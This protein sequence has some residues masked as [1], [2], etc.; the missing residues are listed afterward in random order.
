[1]LGSLPVTVDP[2][3]LADKNSRLV[4]RVAIRGMTRLR[5][6][7]QDDSGQVEVDLSFELAEHSNLRRMRGRLAV[8]V[9]ATCQ[10]CLEPMS[11]KLEAEPDVV[12]LREGELEG[13][14][15]L[16]ADTLMLGQTPIALAELIED[17]LLLAMPMV[18]M[19]PLEE[20][21]ARRYTTG[22][23]EGAGTKIRL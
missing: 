12:L 5:A 21:P 1:M 3:L 6:P 23:G 22:G 15:P 14:L 20:C 8:T 9:N 16:E 19:H 11:V 17:E 2:V 18:P 4:G 7:L 13:S 10:R